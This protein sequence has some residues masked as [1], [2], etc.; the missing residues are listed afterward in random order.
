M[1]TNATGAIIGL[2]GGIASGK[3]TVGALFSKRGIPVIDA[4]ALSRAIVEP[5][6]PALDDIVDAFGASILN[7]DGTLDRNSLGDIVFQDPDARTTLEAI[8]H[9]RIAQAM[10]EQ[11]QQAFSDGH[12]FVLYEAALL[13]ESG[14][15]QWLDALIVVDISPATQLQR[16]RQRDDL[17]ATAAQQRID[18]Q[19]PLDEKRKAA[20]FL[21][22]NDQDLEHT[23][24]QV[25]ELCQQL[26]NRF[27]TAY[28]TPP[29]HDG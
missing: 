16:L 12:P 19:M 3:S 20:D 28:S 22:D 17:S 27:S 24:R 8:T 23:R 29:G 5:G 9:P 13:V 14:S 10:M 6:Q 11:A 21:I 18:A 26:R 15:H 2:T 25:D 7:D 4:D 1:S